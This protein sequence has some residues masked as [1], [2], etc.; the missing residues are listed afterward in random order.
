M[1][2]DNVRLRAMAAFDWKLDCAWCAMSRLTV[3][4]HCIGEAFIGLDAIGASSCGS[5]AETATS[6]AVVRGFSPT[7]LEAVGAC[8]AEVRQQK[9]PPDSR[10]VPRL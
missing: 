7:S 5:K 3:A 2:C 1:C 8:L 10:Q 9:K 4:T 6:E